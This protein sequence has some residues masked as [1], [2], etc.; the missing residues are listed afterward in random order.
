M[1][2]VR[3]A[4]RKVQLYNLHMW[5][6]R[7][8][9]PR[10]LRAAATRPAVVLTGARQ[11]GKT[12]LARRL[13]PEHR[14]VSLDLPSE[15]AQA[16]SDPDLFLSRHPAPVVIDEV[17]YAPGLFRHV[18]AAIERTRMRRGMFVLT[19]SQPFNLMQGVSES[20]AGRASVIHIEG[21]SYAEAISARPRM[22]IAQV[23]LRGGFP[24]LYATPSVPVAD[25]MRSYVAT[26]LE[27]DLRS[28]MRVGNL[29]D[30]ERFLRSAALRTAQLLNKAELARDVSISP[31]T[32]NDW[33]AMLE[34]GGVATLLEPWFA[35]RGKSLSKTPKLY[36]CDSGLAAFLM[37]I[38]D[39]EALRDS[40]L[41][42]ALWETF[43]CAEI[44]KAIAATD[45]PQQ[46]HFWRDR[47]KEADFLLHAG[48]R[49]TLADAKWSEHP[50]RADA[51]RIARVAAELPAGRVRSATLI[52]RTPNAFAF[53]A[54]P[55]SGNATARV[56]A[57]P[58]RDVPQAL[59]LADT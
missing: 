56:S 59:G 18:K 43:V 4:N 33:L 40:P 52:C 29:R 41:V 50:D 3:L 28:Q 37:G 54:E 49:F 35:N 36:L 38:G 30:F 53:P 47:T 13:F 12:A 15:A 57:I 20:L 32:A 34:R 39:A 21:L 23:M 9:E 5:I 2:I 24:E 55:L 6:R 46:L 22:S 58:L 48:G 7:A 42:G 19:G 26:Y 17:Q 31:P 16:E 51:A 14:Y 25:F 44:R 27:R 8:I 45:S 11:T 10:I 1:T